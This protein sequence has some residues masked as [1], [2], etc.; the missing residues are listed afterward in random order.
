MYISNS[1]QGFAAVTSHCE[2]VMLRPQRSRS[3][4]FAGEPLMQHAVCTRVKASAT[5]V[6][7]LRGPAA[8]G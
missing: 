2:N 3:E 5:H 4:W 8:V 1:A 6:S 7:T